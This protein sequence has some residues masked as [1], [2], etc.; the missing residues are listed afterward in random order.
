MDDRLLVLLAPRD[1]INSAFG[2]IRIYEMQRRILSQETVD[3]AKVALEPKDA[4]ERS[5]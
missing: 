3:L 2:V 4:V 5:K 1:F